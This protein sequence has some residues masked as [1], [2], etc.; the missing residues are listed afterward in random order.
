MYISIHICIY[1]IYIHIC[2]YIYI[3]IY[4]II[5]L[6]FTSRK[7]NKKTQTNKITQSP[8]TNVLE[9]TWEYVKKKKIVD[10]IQIY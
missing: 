6:H 1:Y 10:Q 9:S 2:V 5:N 7:T 4:M 3:Y 8:D